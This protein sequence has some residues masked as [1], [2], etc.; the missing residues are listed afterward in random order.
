MS[1]IVWDQSFNVGHAEVDRQHRQ[2]MT[3]MNEME[4][5]LLAPSTYNRLA[6]LNILERLLKFADKHFRL[7]KELMQEYGYSETSLCSHWRSYKIFDANIYALY[8][9]LLGG[10]M[11]FDS[12]ILM[13][14]RD[15][16]FN[17]ILK[18]DQMMFQNVFADISQRDYHEPAFAQAVS[19]Y[20][21]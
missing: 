18:E 9:E 14:I 4:S 19:G 5:L 1:L 11:V 2:F 6:R 10:E 20:R 15:E 7:E 13:V 12:N 21:S 17:H 16:F 3:I 8:R